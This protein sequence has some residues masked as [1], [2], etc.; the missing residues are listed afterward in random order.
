MGLAALG[1]TDAQDIRSAATGDVHRIMLGRCDLPEDSRPPIPL[2][3][4]DGNGHFGAAV[5]IVR[6]LQLSAHLPPILVIGVGYPVPLLR[7]TIAARTRDL[8]PSADPAYA[9]LFDPAPRMGGADAFLSFLRDELPPV[10]SRDA[11]ALAPLPPVLFGHS[12]GGLFACYALLRDPAAFSGYLVSSPS[13]WWHGGAVFAQEDRYSAEHGDLPAR[14]VLGIGDGE[15]YPGR[16][17]EAGRLDE[18]GRELAGAWPIDMLADARRLAARLSGRGY[19]GLRLDLLEWPGEM[20]L[21][22]WPA[23]LSRGLRLL[24]DAP[25]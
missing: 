25:L 8:T 6:S 22:V 7:D 10:L 5:D 21:S 15:D 9:A 1:L 16:Q 24:F 2:I 12:L 18:A 13:L 11:G 4:L 20:H 3:V 19:P 23:T 14:V 17:R